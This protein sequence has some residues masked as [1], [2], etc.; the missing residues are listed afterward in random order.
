M[1]PSVGEVTRL[2]GELRN[3]HPE[4]VD[5]LVAV[6]HKELHRRAARYMRRERF[7]H[8]LQT[9]ALL[10]EAYLRLVSQ[11][12]IDWQDRAHFFRAASRLM[13]EILVDYA[14]ARNTRKRGGQVERLSL[15]GAADASP[16]PDFSPARA[17]E[18]VEPGQS[19]DLNE[20]IQLDKALNSLGRLDAR[21][22][23]IVD[24]RFFGGLTEEETAET[25]GISLRTVKREWRSARLWLHHEMST[26]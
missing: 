14:R 26:S 22:E 19:I 25:L 9:T 11:K 8:T 24:L 17:R 23:Q 12:D 20:L 2:L 10:N 5:K 3:G 16:T 13:R 18:L 15:D 21:Q 7:V 4:A 6:V 1:R